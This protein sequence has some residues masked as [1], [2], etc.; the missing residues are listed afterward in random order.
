MNGNTSVATS[1]CRSVIQHHDN[2]V[3]AVASDSVFVRS[4]ILC[5]FQNCFGKFPNS[6]LIQTG[7]S[8]YHEEEIVAAKTLL[9][10]FVDSLPSKPDGLPRHRKRQAGDENRRLNCDD[11]LKL[12][13]TQLTLRCLR[14]CRW[15]SPVYRRSTLA[16]LTFAAWR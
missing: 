10:D 7:S 1:W 14:L 13:L 16:M 3:M 8:F 2:G 9:F 11:I 15:I 12:P 5:Y 6:A 4:E